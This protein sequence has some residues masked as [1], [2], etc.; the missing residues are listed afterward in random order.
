[1][2]NADPDIEQRLSVLVITEAKKSL[3]EHDKKFSG[4]PCLHR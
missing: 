2:E 4:F 1:M 3:M